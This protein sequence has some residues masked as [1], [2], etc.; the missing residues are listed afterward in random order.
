MK[1]NV[2]GE[3]IMNE[4]DERDEERKDNI[5]FFC[6]QVMIAINEIKEMVKEQKNKNI[7]E[8]KQQEL[9]FSGCL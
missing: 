1:D 2:I 8:S 4:K 5:E 6:Y 7:E 9:D 3:K